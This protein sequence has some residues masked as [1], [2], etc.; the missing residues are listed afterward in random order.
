MHAI[1]LV[2]VQQIDSMLSST[3]EGQ[4]PHIKVIDAM[5]V[6]HTI[7]KTSDLKI[8]QKSYRCLC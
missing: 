8:V 4:L 3:L 2:Q 1:V 6:L 5:A 7:K